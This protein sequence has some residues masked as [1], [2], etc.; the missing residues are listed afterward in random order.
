MATPTENEAQQQVL[1]ADD[2]AYTDSD[3]AFPDD[4]TSASTSISS[5]IRAYKYENGRRYH[6]Y[7]E[8]EYVLP[9][10][11]KEQ[12]RL[13]LFHHIFRMILG[14]SLYCAPVPETIHKALDFGTGTGIWAIDLADEK[15]ECEVLGTDISPIQPGWVPPNCKFIIDDITQDWAYGPVFDFIHGRG[16]G[17]TVSDWDALYTEAFDSLKPGGW[18]EMQ[19]Y[20][21][22]YASDDGTLEKA[23]NLTK[24]IDQLNEASAS[25]GKDMNM[26]KKHKGLMEKAGFVNVREQVFKV[27]VGPWAKDKAL[28]E[29]GKYTIIHTIEAVEPFTLAL[30]SRVLGYS[31]DE[32]DVLLAGLRKELRDPEIHIY[33][34][35]HFIYGQ[36]P[37]TA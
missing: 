35:F 9:N 8:G 5:S 6:A 14:G 16:M 10:D 17:G 20:A 11:E 25:F 15:P 34:P 3:S 1:E 33:T 28:K 32:I 22:E 27:P 36:K 26:A 29:I 18:I 7:R 37:E 2:G 21:I 24:W 31:K 19:E 13:D 12:D 30:F 23:K 4:T